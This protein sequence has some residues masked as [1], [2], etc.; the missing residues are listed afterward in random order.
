MEKIAED[1]NIGKIFKDIQKDKAAGVQKSDYE[2]KILNAV[3][4]IISVAFVCGLFM[5]TIQGYQRQ[6]GYQLGL[7][8][9]VGIL[10]GSVP[11]ALPLVLVV[12]MATGCASELYD[13]YADLITRLC[14][15][16]SIMADHQTVVSNMAALQDIASM[17]V[18]YYHEPAISLPH[19]APLLQ[20]LNSDKTGTLT[21]GDM[22][23]NYERVWVNPNTSFSKEDVFEFAAIC[24]NR[25]NKKVGR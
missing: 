17:T 12:T 18:C 23:I 1:T 20:C 2:K 6:E 14:G 19:H 9:M 5:F 13:L 15:R 16:V 8:A 4:I 21:T 22:A 3:A 11:I 7:L 24:A 25:D 10:V